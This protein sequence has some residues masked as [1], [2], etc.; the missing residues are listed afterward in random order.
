MVCNLFW[1]SAFHIY[2]NV[3]AH[4]RF[5]IWDDSG[6]RRQA[7]IQTLEPEPWMWEVQ[8]YQQATRKA[9]TQTQLDM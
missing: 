6:W 3:G 7:R 5:A 1:I 2:H 8:H 9:T 4:G